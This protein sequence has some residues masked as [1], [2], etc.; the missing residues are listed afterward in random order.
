MKI[1]NGFAVL[2][3]GPFTVVIEGARKTWIARV[4]KRTARRW[5]V[6][7][8]FSTWAAAYR[9]GMRMAD[10]IGRERGNS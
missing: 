2:V 10:K 1:E 6:T 3:R 7:R 9:G 8:T 5:L 4:K